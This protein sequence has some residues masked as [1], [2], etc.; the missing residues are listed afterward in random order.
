M[1]PKIKDIEEIYHA[2]LQRGSQAER[3]AYL[4]DVC[5]KNA[6]LRA[7]VEALLK[8][9]EEAGDFLEAPAVD[10]DVTLDT[11]PVIE[12]PGTVIGRY[13]L[14]EK[15]GEGGMA[16]VYMAQQERPIQRKVAL[17][18]IKMGM[19]TKEVIARFEV[20]RQALAMMEHPNIAKVFDAGTTEAG[21]PFFVME[22]VKGVSVTDYCDKN[23]LSTEQ[24]LDLLI[25]VCSAIQHA[26]QKGIIHRDL[27]PTNVMVT[28]HDGEPVPKVIDFGI[29]KATNQRLT[30]KTLFTRYA[31][32]IG[33]PAYM[34][35]E[36]AEMSGLDVDTRTD[37]Y[38]LGVLLYELLTGTTPFDAEKLRS[39]GYLEMQRIIRE[40]EP[41]RPSTKLR[42]IGQDLTDVAG[43][44]DTQPDLLRKSIRGDLDW[45][46]MKSLEKDRTRRYETAHAMAEDIQR[47]L[48]NVPILARSPGT[49]Y[50]LQKYWKRHRIRIVATAVIV[51]LLV[52]T[53]VGVMAYL[54]G[55]K[56]RWARQE[57]LP[58]ITNRAEKG[59]YLAAFVLAEQAEKCIPEDPILLK[60]WPE[61]SRPYTVRPDPDGTDVYYKEY[62]DIDGE[63]L[64]LGRSPLESIR[65]PRGV[66][67]W[68]LV[69]K[70]FETRECGIGGLRDIILVKLQ[71]K[72]SFPEMV[73]IGSRRGDYL[74]DK[75]EVTNEQYKRFVDSGGYNKQQYWK[76]HFVRDGEEVP[77]EQA[78][79]RFVDKTGRPG[80]ATWE[81]G[82]YPEGQ[83]RFPVSGVSWY[84]SAAY[85]EF[86]GK[87]L[88]TVS[89]WFEVARPSAE[90]V[91]IVPFSNFGR[92]PALVGSHHG[93][94]LLGAHDMAGNVREWCFNATDDSGS[95]RHILGGAYS[96]PEYMFNIR[97][98]AT[99]WD[100]SDQ[101]GFRCVKYL[102]PEDSLSP[103]PFEPIERHLRREISRPKPYS[104]EE[105]RSDKRLYS[106]DRT[107]LVARK[108][109]I[110][111]SPVHWR[112]EKI[113]FNAAYGKERV[114]V[115]LFVPKKTRP[116][117][118]PIVF[119]PGA[120]TPGLPSSE[121][122]RDVWT[123][124]YILM[125]GRVVIYP[126]Y[127]GT[128]DRNFE[129][130]L[131]DPSTAPVAYRNRFVQIY[132]D[133]ARTIDYLEDRDDM[134][135]EK[136]AYM[137]FSLGAMKGPLLVALENRIRLAVFIAGGC[138]PWGKP[139]PSA[140]PLRF[141]SRVKVSTL[142]LNGLE[143]AIFS[144]IS[145]KTLFESL[146]TPDEH[147]K[148]LTYPTG[149]VISGDSREKMKRDVLAWLDKYLGPVDE[150]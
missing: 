13:K 33:T 50:R 149:H 1:E 75:Y 69:K 147:K 9:N 24:R 21:R 98:T 4:D 92:G 48:Q 81:G 49:I 12:G 65:F 104:D 79:S 122:L 105:F 101:N 107:D 115:Y 113:T 30:E 94:G 120:G 97:N 111:R 126:I 143:D 19:D 10:P 137:G 15:I 146:G 31:Q 112:T 134:N 89:H 6:S 56:V 88:P 140:D 26:H 136:L 76:H 47:H 93:V 45:I 58:I 130:S 119:F 40:E 5:R 109:S 62:S 23:K 64:Y 125:S 44:R 77:W 90:A 84:E 3:A 67:R 52:G 100:R 22:L 59:D 87:S 32:M 38:S 72:N 129:H 99:P 96:D 28:L 138:K 63:W 7:R 61:I 71:P 57:A 55:L 141:A 51:V 150:K 118:Q 18:I 46:V 132:Q 106:Y 139:I 53:I 36:Q 128:F 148:H 108:E 54:R 114:T 116:P 34:S 127:K 103:S 60:L 117:Y 102:V 8:A 83:A 39:A 95:Q 74:I 17:K 145:Q 135:L 73:N 20:E 41:T 16:V 91:V 42:A 121:S 37:I 14:L 131:P 11:S 82:T 80:P 142:M 144:D 124:D 29:A 66:Y 86:A 78:V 85:A 110:D 25:R 70:G 133:L 35:P 123:F 68:K 43:N 27:K 2:A